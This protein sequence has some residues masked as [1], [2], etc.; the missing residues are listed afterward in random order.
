MRAMRHVVAT[1]TAIRLVLSARRDLLLEMLPC[2]TRSPCSRVRI[3]AL[4]GRPSAVA[5]LAKAVAAVE[6]RAGVDSAGH[7]WYRERINRRCWRRSRRPGRPR[8]NSQSHEL[9]GRLAEENHPWGAPR[10]FGELPKLGIVVSERTVSR[11]LVGRPKRPSQTWRTFV[12]NHLGQFTW[13]SDRS[14]DTTGSSDLAHDVRA[15][16]FR[17]AEEFRVSGCPGARRRRG[18][19]SVLPGSVKC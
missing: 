14:S 11:D 1:V 10:I 3:G 4:G 17:L 16:L 12:A 9:I 13:R 2:T 18:R 19:E 7:R 8:I 6:R 15:G 5:D